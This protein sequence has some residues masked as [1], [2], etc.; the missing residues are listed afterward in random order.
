MKA[1][2]I[3]GTGTISTA[4]SKL[5]VE[6]GWELYL[7]NRGN[8]IS[9][10]PEGARVITADI[11]D[12]LSVSELIKDMKFDVIADFIAFET[13][14]IQRDI[15]LF[16]N[17]TKQFIFISSASAYQKPLSHYKITESTP[18]ANP[19]WQYSRNKIACEERLM[20][21]YREN[22]FP[23]TI[24]RPSHTYSEGSIPLAVH[25]EKGAWQVIDRI[26]KGKPVIIHGDGS[27]LWTITHNSDFAK[28]F[29]GIMGN[30]AAIGEAIHITSDEAL[31]WNKI[32]DCIGLALDMEVKKLHVTTDF[33][34]ECQA[35][36]EGGLIGD[37][38]NTV[39]FDN[40]KIKRLVPDFVATVRFDQGIKLS[41][42]YMLTHPELQIA[43]EEFDLFCDRII[44]AQQEAVRYFK[45]L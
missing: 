31:T 18:L 9:K 23:I 13:S 14:Q 37:K 4:I 20:E 42:E 33:L 30:Q 17:K 41:I 6:K 34:V 8:N 36:F 2:F 15:R 25:G 29:V 26:M 38:A 3:G 1:L 11:N 39:V 27:S 19:Y 40:S 35:D 12:E 45:G 16:S 32:Y 10:V 5:A 44:E 22:N 28:A 43:D 21:E 24:I 7:L